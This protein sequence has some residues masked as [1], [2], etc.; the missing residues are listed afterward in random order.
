MAEVQQLR[1]GN[2]YEEEGQ[3]WRVLEH[4]HIK[5]ARGGANYSPQVA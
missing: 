2:M 4:Q 1:K 5:V 3:L